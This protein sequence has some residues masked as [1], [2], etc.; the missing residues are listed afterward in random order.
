MCVHSE[1]GDVCIVFTH[2]EKPDAL[3]VNTFDI[4]L[5]TFHHYPSQSS[6]CHKI[7]FSLT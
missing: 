7:F 6:K 2:K 4:F 3:M 5:L 1:A